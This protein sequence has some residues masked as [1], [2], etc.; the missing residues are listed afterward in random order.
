MSNIPG[1]ATVVSTIDVLRALS[2]IVTV[3]WTVIVDLLEFLGGSRF[4]DEYTWCRRCGAD[5]PPENRRPWGSTCA[6]CGYMESR[7][8]PTDD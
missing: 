5:V 7:Y 3:L 1:E 4:N 8:P 2:A 6:R